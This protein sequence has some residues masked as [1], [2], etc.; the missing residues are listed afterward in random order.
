MHSRCP[1]TCYASHSRLCRIETRRRSVLLF[2]LR[3]SSR[4]P[5]SPYFTV[6]SVSPHHVLT[7]P[8]A[9]LNTA[10][11][12]GVSVIT[13]LNPSLLLRRTITRTPYRHPH[14]FS[15]PHS[16]TVLGASHTPHPRTPTCP[17]SRAQRHRSPPGAGVRTLLGG[18][19]LALLRK[20]LPSPRGR[21]RLPPLPSSTLLLL[22]PMAAEGHRVTSCPFVLPLA[23][24]F[25]TDSPPG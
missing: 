16:L 23:S 21:C 5:S 7:A 18:G 15:R 1:S 11:T 17:A 13:P 24:A 10:F 20:S 4:H 22:P 8:S 12:T 14:P 6:D 19:G 3:S 25:P 2:P 9:A